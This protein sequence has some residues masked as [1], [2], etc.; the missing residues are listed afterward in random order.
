MLLCVVELLSYDVVDERIVDIHG[1][2]LKV[3]HALKS[4]L[5]VLRKFLVDHG[6]LHLFE[7]KVMLPVLQHAFL[8]MNM[9]SAHA[10][11]IYVVH[12]QNQAVGEA[13]DNS[14]E[15]QV[16]QVASDYRLPV[17]KDILLPDH[18]TPLNPKVS[19]YLLYGRDPSVCDPYLSDPSHQANAIIQQV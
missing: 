4:V 6:V 11:D 19:R 15:N 12:L 2:P 16:N 5:G 18:R 17:N 8:C 14:K 1:A 10:I 13:H 7:R 9:N 3:L